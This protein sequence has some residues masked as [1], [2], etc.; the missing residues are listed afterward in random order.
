M[1]I[2]CYIL[3]LLGNSNGERSMSTLY[4]FQTILIREDKMCIQTVDFLQA[5]G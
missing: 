3:L 5:V 4:S 2:I 1:E